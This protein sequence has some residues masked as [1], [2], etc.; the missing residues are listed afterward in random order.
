MRRAAGITVTTCLLAAGCTVSTPAGPS[1][2]QSASDPAFA[3]AST[4][5]VPADVTALA[6]LDGS[7]DYATYQQALDALAHVCTEPAS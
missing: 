3:A 5:S 6:Q 2:N 4:P 7:A 1:D